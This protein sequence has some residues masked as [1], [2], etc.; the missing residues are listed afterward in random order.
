MIMNCFCGM[1]YR[2]KAFSLISSRGDWQRSSPSQISDTPPA[3]PELVQNQSSSFVEWR[4]A[5]AKT[6]TPQRSRKTMHYLC[7][8]T[9]RK[10]IYIT[11]SLCKNIWPVKYKVLFK[12]LICFILIVI[13][14]IIFGRLALFRH[15]F[16]RCQLLCNFTIT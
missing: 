16:N 13:V 14:I 7:G 15:T 11:I 5:V 9:D 12:M 8:E 3:G 2:R 4:C 1:V 6:T 10:T